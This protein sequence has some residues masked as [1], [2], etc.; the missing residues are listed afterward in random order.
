MPYSLENKGL[1]VAANW[2]PLVNGSEG[3]HDVVI[4]EVKA[5]D[6]AKPNSVWRGGDLEVIKY[7]VRFVG[8]KPSM[9]SVG[10]VARELK[11]HFSYEDQKCRFRY[12]IFSDSANPHYQQKGV[13]YFQ[14]EPMVR[15]LAE[16]RGD[17][18]VNQG[19]GM[20]SVHY[21]WDKMINSIFKIANERA[22]PLPDRCER[23]IAELR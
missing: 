1:F 23:I 9:S 19:I 16:V 14:V 12:A 3:K 4:A 15:F 7:I 13:S 6:D 11:E 20:A 21:Q 5:G 18:W 10:K 8:L 2:G 17:C 22:A